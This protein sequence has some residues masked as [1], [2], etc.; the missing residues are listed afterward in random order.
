MAHPALGDVHDTLP[1]VQSMP[2]HP[3]ARSVHG[4]VRVTLCA[5]QEEA[6]RKHAAE[7]E[8]ARMRAEVRAVQYVAL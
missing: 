1:Q 7:A 4:C 2:L 8:A 5:L 6:Q 3:P